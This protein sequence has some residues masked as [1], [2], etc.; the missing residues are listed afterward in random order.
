MYVSSR[1]AGASQLGA[2]GPGSPSPRAREAQN[3]TP[4]A[5]PDRTELSA[6]SKLMS[7][8]SQLEQADPGQVKGAVSQLVAELRKVAAN[9]SGLGAKMMAQLASKLGEVADGGTRAN[10]AE[11]AGRGPTETGSSGLGPTRVSQ[12]GA[13]GA[14]SPA[15]AAASSPQAA[16][17]PA[18]GKAVAA[19]RAQSDRGSETDAARD[20]LAKVLDQLDAALEA[21]NSG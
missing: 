15:A 8:V 16:A 17:S 3:D 21:T 18:S 5:S 12:P 9:E 2:I 11:A 4:A 13:A 1:S 7:K 14:E 10:L 19:Y 20:A 6:S